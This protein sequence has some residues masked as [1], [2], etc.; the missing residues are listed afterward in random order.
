MTIYT[1]TRKF[2]GGTLKGLEHTAETSAKFAVGFE[3]E[4]PCGGSP[5]IITAVTESTV[6]FV[7]VNTETA[8]ELTQRSQHTFRVF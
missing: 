5:Y 8:Y 6:P 1:V 3:C 2:T 7:E 4:N